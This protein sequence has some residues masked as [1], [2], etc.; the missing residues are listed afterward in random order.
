M[1]SDELKSKIQ[2]ELSDMKTNGLFKAEK[3]VEG[4]TGTEIKVDGK[5]LINLC[6]N[7]YLGTSQQ[8]KVIK[9]AQKSLKEYSLGLNSVRFIVRSSCLFQEATH[10]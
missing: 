7:N 6:A 3:V 1:F 8:K 9:A 5:K 10:S 4:H 2:T